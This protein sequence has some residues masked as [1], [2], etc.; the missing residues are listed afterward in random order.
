MIELATWV[1]SAIVVIGYQTFNE[2]RE[3]QPRELSAEQKAIQARSAKIS[4]SCLEEFRKGLTLRDENLKSHQV[5]RQAPNAM[6]CGIVFSKLLSS[7]Q[8]SVSLVPLSIKEKAPSCPQELTKLIHQSSTEAIFLISLQEQ[9]WPTNGGPPHTW[10]R[11]YESYPGTASDGRRDT[12][13]H[14]LNKAMLAF[15]NREDLSA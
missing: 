13:H 12:L 1:G 9:G 6:F 14:A 11:L 3:Q 7:D 4:Q 5:T 15:N 2:W 10:I 8:T